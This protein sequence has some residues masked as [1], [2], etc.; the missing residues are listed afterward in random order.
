MTAGGDA[1]TVMRRCDVLG[2]CSEEPGR[3]T[4]PFA[5]HVMLQVH[6]HVTSWMREA[7]MAVRKDNVG[8]LLARYESDTGTSTLILG[9]HLDSVRGAGRYDGPLGVMIAIAAVERLHH[10]GS[11]L[12]F[13]IEVVG[14]ADEEGLRYGTPYLGSKALAGAF[15]VADLDR[16]DAQGVSMADAVRTFGGDPGRLADDRWG[17]GNLLG[18]VEVHIEQGPVLEARDLPVGIVSAINGQSRY[19]LTFIGEAAHAGTTPMDRRK[20]ALVAAAEFVLEVEADARETDGLVATVGQLAVSPGVTNVVPGEAVLSLDVRHADDT[21]RLERS[22]RLLQRARDIAARRGLSVESE[23]VAENQSVPC[24]PP[25]A[26]LLT[27]AVQEL[28]HPTVTLGSGAGHDAAV[29]AGITDV[30]MLFVRCKGGVSHNPAESVTEEDV[31]V[32]IDVLGKFMELLA[33][34]R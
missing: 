13:V 1:A 6:E 30:A 31:A 18:Y 28:G 26:S 20:D 14:F 24:S 27:Q 25:L 8:N 32:A 9:S 10:S 7:G 34:K 3:L 12:P 23:P 33:A 16:T 22:A 21:I 5:S 29:M 4:R 11:R 19:R 15:D 17:G 2:A